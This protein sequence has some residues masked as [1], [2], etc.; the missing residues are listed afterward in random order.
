MLHPGV[1]L[2]A[3][4][5]LL[6]PG[7]G[8]RAG[9]GYG[10]ALRS[11]DAALR[12]VSLLRVSK[13]EVARW[14]D[15]E[16]ERALEELVSAVRRR[17]RAVELVRQA[18]SEVAEWTARAVEA[19]CSAEEL[20]SALAGLVP[21]MPDNAR[22]AKLSAPTV[23]SQREPVGADPAERLFTIEQACAAGVLP[24]KAN[25][26]RARKSQAAR[27]GVAFPEG[28][29]VVG[30]RARAYPEAQLKDSWARTS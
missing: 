1:L 14:L 4:E 20:A 2:L 30:S 7:L 12:V 11:F 19:R 17:R 23:V 25:A 24:V 6:H 16:I 22:L 9:A 21:V 28:Q 5:V 10:A 8:C 27:R 18:D 26:V 3:E 29:A 13:A 15:V